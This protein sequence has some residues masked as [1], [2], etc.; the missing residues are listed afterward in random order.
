MINKEVILRQHV[1]GEITCR[2]GFEP[3]KQLQTSKE[4]QITSYQY[5]S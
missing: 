2:E 5:Q 3:H 4:R 1:N